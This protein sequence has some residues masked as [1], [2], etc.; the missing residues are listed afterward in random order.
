MSDLTGELVEFGIP[1]LMC[2]AMLFFANRQRLAGLFI[3]FAVGI[4][5]ALV[6]GLTRGWQVAATDALA[7]VTA[8]AGTLMRYRRLQPR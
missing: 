7:M 6:M 3:A 4:G 5:W 1:F 8:L 2:L